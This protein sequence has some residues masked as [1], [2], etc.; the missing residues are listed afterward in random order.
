MAICWKKIRLQNEWRI[1]S[2]SGHTINWKLL[3]TFRIVCVC[4]WKWQIKMSTSMLWF[5]CV[6]VSNGFWILC[7]CLFHGLFHGV[8]AFICYGVICLTYG[9]QNKTNPKTF[10]IPFHFSRESFVLDSRIR[11][12]WKSSHCFICAQL[13]SDLENYQADKLKEWIFKFRLSYYM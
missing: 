4:V 2:Q 11:F 3:E 9:E 7:V 13:S 8:D 6:C 5:F 12:N 10:Y 1:I